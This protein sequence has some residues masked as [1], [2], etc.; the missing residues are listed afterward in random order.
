MSTNPILDELHATRAKL[1]AEAGG[2]LHRYVEEARARA[3]ASGRPIAEPTQRTI[4]CVGAAKSG[5][6]PIENPP[7]T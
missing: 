3:L 6:L 1:L 4:R 7:T 2:D 5:E